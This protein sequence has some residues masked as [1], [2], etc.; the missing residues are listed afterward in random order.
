MK[1]NVNMKYHQG[2]VQLVWDKYTYG[3]RP[4]LLMVDPVTG[5][6]ICTATVNLPEVKLAHDEII[7][8]DWSENE[9]ALQSLID[10]K[11]VSNPIRQI[12]TGFVLADVCKLLVEPDHV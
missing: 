5:E 3:D 9:G 8:K 11:I 6:A 7:I 1:I 4:C 2:P 12:P 10:A